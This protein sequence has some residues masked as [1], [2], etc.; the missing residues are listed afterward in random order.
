MAD[1]PETGESAAMLQTLWAWEPTLY[2][3]LSRDN[4]GTGQFLAY[5][6]TS[7]VQFATNSVIIFTNLWK[8][9]RSVDEK[10]YDTA[11]AC[12]PCPTA[13]ANGTG[14]SISVNEK[15]RTGKSSTSLSDQRVATNRGDGTSSRSPQC[16]DAILAR[17]VQE[18][19]EVGD[20]KAQGHNPL[21]IAFTRRE[22]VGM[23][24]A[25]S[26]EAVVSLVKTDSDRGATRTPDDGYS[27][28]SSRCESRPE[29]NRSWKG[30]GPVLYEIVWA[31]RKLFLKAGE[32]E[33]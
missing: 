10:K 4:V 12:E 7:V 13:T 26:S 30:R 33:K 22:S 9:A 5:L 24:T 17:N 21:A 14:T 20:E 31:G 18:V 28:K 11:A 8:D 16:T 15:T 29:A 2:G 25:T 19:L 6:Y 27:Y 3:R 1:S 32:I 23:N